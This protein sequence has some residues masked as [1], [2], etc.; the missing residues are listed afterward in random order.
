MITVQGKTFASY[1]EAWRDAELRIASLHIRTEELKI[2]MDDLMREVERDAV[3]LQEHP[4]PEEAARIGKNLQ[5]VIE[6]ART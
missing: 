1:E 5:H 3:F 4:A 6:E 2:R